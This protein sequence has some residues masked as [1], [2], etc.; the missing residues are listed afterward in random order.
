MAG[1][2][3]KSRGFENR[4]VLYLRY[5]T[6]NQTDLSIEYQR[7]KA[8]EYCE[9]A[10]YIIV[11]SFIDEARSGTT[12]KREAFQQMIEEATD[13]PT[14]SKVIVFSFNRFA[15]NKDFDGYYKIILIIVT[16]LS[17]K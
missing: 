17:W 3:K 7:E 13:N 14:W 5:S 12:D 6:H 1:R 15:R 4:A 16:R 9:K 2:S 11:K 10:G 8:T